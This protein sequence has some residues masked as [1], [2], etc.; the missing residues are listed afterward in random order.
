MEEALHRAL[1]QGMEVG[2]GAAAA[3]P[4]LATEVDAEVGA[5]EDDAEEDDGGGG[6]LKRQLSIDS[7][8][9]DGA[10]AGEYITAAQTASQAAADDL[11]A[12][13][14]L[15]NVILAYINIYD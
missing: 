4:A 6:A 13:A 8:H 3:A 5:D 12:L 7:I 15:K 1:P 11:T 2:G 9:G 10:G 14:N